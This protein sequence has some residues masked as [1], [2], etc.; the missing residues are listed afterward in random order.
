M[1]P[2]MLW[3]AAILAAAGLLCTLPAMA[4]DATGKADPSAKIDL[5][6][7][8][9]SVARAREGDEFNR[10]MAAGLPVGTG[11]YMM[12]K[13]DEHFFIEMDKKNSKL[14]AFKDDKGTVLAKPGNATGFGQ[15]NWMPFSPDISD[16]GHDVYLSIRS[17]KTPADDATAIDLKA[18]LAL[19]AGKD[20]KTDKV[21]VTLKTGEKVTLAGVQ[22]TLQKVGEAKW[23][24]SK[25]EVTFN[26][27]ESFAKI[28][29]L[30][31]LGSGGNEIK[32]RRT[33]SSRIGAFGK[34]TY[35]QSYGLEQD[36]AGQAVTIQV[37]YF[38]SLE[39][40]PVKI[41][42]KITLGL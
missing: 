41:D 31:F 3:T 34:T 13:S 40:V 22:V 20:P 36:V 28:R 32:S 33:G 35:T 4:Q 16:D 11:V 10:S 5:K 39:T 19:I 6:V 37:D 17:K 1:K 15:D 42:K 18:T 38:E 2:A 12:A 26:S 21:K 30:K 8:G 23:G 25:V 9:L 27:T 14:S 29:E 7:G 24:R